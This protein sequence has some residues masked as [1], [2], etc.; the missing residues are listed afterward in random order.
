MA[1][2]QPSGPLHAEEIKA[3]IRIA[4]GSLAAFERKAKL[5]TGSV[6]DALRNGRPEVE[7]AI[8]KL[9]GLPAEKL[10]PSR[11]IR[12]GRKLRSTNVEKVSTSRR[13][14]ARQMV[15]GV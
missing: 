12:R 11:F 3:R 2:I 14:R 6:R 10:W 5:P 7:R 8:A 9:I 1:I 4:C 13:A 15:T